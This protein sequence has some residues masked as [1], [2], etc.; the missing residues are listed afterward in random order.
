MTDEFRRDCCWFGTP[1][2]S[3]ETPAKLLTLYIKHSGL[4]ALLLLDIRRASL[5]RQENALGCVSTRREDYCNLRTLFFFSLQK[6][7]LF[8]AFT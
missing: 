2:E 6:I 7:S 5:V 3:P 1:H 8:P 4:I